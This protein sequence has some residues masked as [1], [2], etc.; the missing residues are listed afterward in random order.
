QLPG[1]SCYLD[2]GLTDV[3]Y[4]GRDNNPAM[5]FHDDNS[6]IVA[7]MTAQV[8]SIVSQTMTSVTSF[9]NATPYS[10]KAVDSSKLIQTSTE[11]FTGN[12][13]AIISNVKPSSYTMAKAFPTFKLF[14]ME[15]NAQKPF[16]AYDNFYSY[17][18]VLDMEIIR[19]RDKPD[20]AVIQISNLL[21]LL[22]QHMFDGTPQGR[23]EA[24]L[25]A[26]VTTNIPANQ[27][28]AVPAGGVASMDINEPTADAWTLDNRF[29]Q[30]AAHHSI[31]PTTS[32]R[33][34]D[35]KF[36][37]RFFALQTGTKVQ[38]R[39]GFSNNPDLLIPVF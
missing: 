19:Y 24:R 6:D 30:I 29:P 33:Q 25:H 35:N 10:D 20:T 32:S 4:V 14:L 28:L 39:M 5:Y 17:A 3:T 26:P 9:E 36:P 38:V 15:D 23:Q 27:Q 21:H 7:S 1:H 13:Q 37:L 11:S 18:T 12:A 34:I 8:S 2:M 22:D 16:Y 31:D